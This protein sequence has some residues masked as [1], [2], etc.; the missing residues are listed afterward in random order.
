M[1]IIIDSDVANEIDDQ[2]AIAYAFSRQDFFEILAVTV[3]PYK[4]SWQNTVSYRDGLIE[5]R[6]ELYRLF[7]YLGV[8]HSHESPM[9]YL[10]CEGFL[11]EGYNSTNPAVERIIELAKKNRNITIVSIGTL[12]NV[13][14]AL[15]LEPSIA[16]KIKVVWLGTDNLL[17]DDYKDAN[18]RK[19]IKAFN[20]VAKS[21]IDF[22]I[23]PSYLARTFVTSTYEFSKN[24]KGTQIGKY[25]NTLMTRFVFIKEDLGIKTIYDIGPVAYLLN[26]KEF[27]TKKIPASYVVKDKKVKLSEDRM[28]N[29]VMTLP[30]N[31]AVWIDF[32]KAINENKS[33]YIKPQIWFTS[34]T[35]FYCE[36][37]ITRH[38]VPFE[39][40][41]EMNNQLVKRW[42]SVVS[43]NDTV[44][45][46][47][48]F[49]DL[50]ISHYD[51]VKKL[52]GNIILICGNYEEE[53]FKRDFETFKSRM[54]NLG[55]ADVIQGGMYLDEK[56]LGQ[57]VYLTHIPTRHAK[58]CI[59]LFGHVHS[60][61]LVKKFGFNVASPYHYFTPIGAK[62]VKR[63]IDFIQHH[64]D[65]DVFV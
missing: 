55:F 20:E 13:A 40:V 54:L 58:D 64:A 29:Y 39:S 43:P 4:V 45:H 6:N 36:S 21:N 47:G 5:S 41:E 38:Q 53:I 60:L 32:L 65:E 7:R 51:I 23:F 2:F 11:S 57:K 42:N 48:D 52:N 25:L 50:D 44:Y 35:H 56:V 15:R 63:Y 16:S 59:T 10:G 9:G 61:N 28:I 19:D 8:K 14:M 30:K 26:K 3:A 49:A 24:I 34:D 18:Y 62:S 22:T 17:L 12:T 37:K 27:V 46:I 1:K 31:S 33:S